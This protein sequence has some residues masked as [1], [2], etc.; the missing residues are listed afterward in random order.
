VDKPLGVTVEKYYI[1]RAIM[2]DTANAVGIDSTKDNTITV[3][4]PPSLSANINFAFAVVAKT[5]AGALLK[6]TI[7]FAFLPSIPIEGSFRL[8]ARSDNASDKILLSWTA[9][10]INTILRFYVYRSGSPDTGSFALLDSTANFSYID[11]PPSAIG[12]T[13]IY[14]YQIKGIPPLGDLRSTAAKQR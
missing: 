3:L 2:P 1:Y 9:P 14:V 13:K 4:C 12:V 7:A 5:S 6:S 11:V 8:T 10:P